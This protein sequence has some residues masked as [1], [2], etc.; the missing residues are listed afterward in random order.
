[1]RGPEEL[2]ERLGEGD[3]TMGVDGAAE[4]QEGRMA[5]GWKVGQ[6]DHGRQ[7]MQELTHDRAVAETIWS[8]VHERGLQGLEQAREGS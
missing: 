8:E 5:G 6:A 7:S 2:T 3:R 4:C 1:M